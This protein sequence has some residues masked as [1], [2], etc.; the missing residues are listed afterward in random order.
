MKLLDVNVVV[1]RFREDH[2]HH[3]AI[4]DWFSRVEEVG[5]PFGV[6]PGIF[7]SV[8]RL[9]TDDRVFAVPAPVDEVFSYVRAL[10]AQPTFVE[11]RL[12]GRRMQLFESL[13]RGFAASGSLVPDAYLAAIAIEN[14]ATM[15]SLDRDFA[16]FDGLDWE[17]P[18]V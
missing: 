6:T 7:S 10:R 17:R 13:V 1:A 4:C 8:V 2:P 16:R 18:P 3:G 15:V 11:P 14:G 5:Q 9:V 12:T